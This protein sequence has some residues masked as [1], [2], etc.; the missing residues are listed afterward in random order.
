MEIPPMDNGIGD[1]ETSDGAIEH[2]LHLVF[3]AKRLLKSRF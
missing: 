2:Y 3:L 1:S